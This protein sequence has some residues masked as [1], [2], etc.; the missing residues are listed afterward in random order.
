[1]LNILSAGQ[2]C[3]GFHEWKD[4]S[5]NIEGCEHLNWKQSNMGIFPRFYFALWIDFDWSNHRT[6]RQEKIPK[7]A[8]VLQ[9]VIKH[10]FCGKKLG[11]IFQGYWLNAKKSENEIYWTICSIKC[12]Y[13][14]KVS[15]FK[16]LLFGFT[17]NFE[18]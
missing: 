15:C 13:S 4:M 1:M 8:D 5:C 9:M 11:L 12:F 7:S 17:V 14:K 3:Q 2:N 16:K 18:K 6:L 10:L